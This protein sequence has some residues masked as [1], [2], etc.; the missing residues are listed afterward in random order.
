MSLSDIVSNAG[1]AFYAQVALV[2]FFLVFVGIVVYVFLRR[3]SSWD[4]VRNL[5]LEEDPPASVEG[6]ER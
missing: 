4:H 6:R 2:I 1:F 5:P 3:K